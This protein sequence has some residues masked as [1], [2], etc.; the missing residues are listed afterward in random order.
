MRFS[1]GVVSLLLALSALP[2]GPER[3][4]G[5]ECPTGRISYIFIDNNSIFDLSA[6]DPDTKLRWAYATANKLHVRTRE[7][8]IMDELLFQVGECLDPLLLEETERLLRAYRFIGYA[9]VFAIPQPDGDHHVNVYTRDEWTTKF[10][11]GFRVDEGVKI[12]GLEVTEE[13]FMGR[14]VLL[15]GFLRKDKE[16]QDLG[17]E[18]ETPRLFQS[19]W[20]GRVSVGTTRTGN[21]FEMSLT[22]PFVGEV[23]RLAARHDFLWRETVFSYSTS[24]HPDYTHLLVPFLD[25]RWDASV[26]WRMG[27]PGDLFLVGLGI[28]RESVDFRAFPADLEFIVDKKFSNPVPVDSA[29]VAEIEDQIQTR[30]ANR[31]SLF[32]GKRNVHFIQRRG[33]DAL[34]GVQDVGVGTDL[35]LGLGKALRSFQE[36]GGDRSDDLHLQA[37]VFGGGAWDGWVMNAQAAVE[38]L[39]GGSGRTGTDAWRDVFVDTDFL[40]YWQPRGDSYH[41]VLFRLSGSGGWSVETPFQLTLGGRAAVRGYREDD[42][43][44]S[45]R[46]L[47]TLEDRVFVPSPSPSLFDMGLVFFLDLGRVSAGD[48]PFGANSGWRGTA[49]AGLRI[50]LPPS[51]TN[52]LRIDVAMPLDRKSRIKDLILRVSL[53]ELLG[54]LPGMRDRQILRS[55]RSGLRPTLLTT[56]W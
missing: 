51:T 4:V 46:F 28:S 38:G 17:L 27:Q 12:E 41:T 56:P 45:K 1:P 37:T 52:T 29:G 5:Q 54:L 9:D 40:L 18:L 19:R 44:G 15:R 34:R 6:L 50:G 8:F 43:P 10:D 31:I 47:M 30:R 11:L 36:G 48:V 55:F 20:D 39:Y 16:V 24:G 2:V 26:G 7:E 35:F 25:Q 42:Y 32:L 49:G 22:Y 23:G 53:S 21:F 3:G 13:N 14:G 33:L